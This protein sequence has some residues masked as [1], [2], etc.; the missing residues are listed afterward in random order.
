MKIRP[1]GAVVIFRARLSVYGSTPSRL[2]AH[3]FSSGEP[4][5]GKDGDFVHRMCSLLICYSAARFLQPLPH[6]LGFVWS[7]K[8]LVDFCRLR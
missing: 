1:L 7:L 3:R 5:M 2:A 6:S 8:P 4:G